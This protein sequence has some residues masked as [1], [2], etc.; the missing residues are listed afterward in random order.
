M[1]EEYPG[2]TVL[3]RP[4]VDALL[5]RAWTHRVSVISAGAGFG[6]TTA[7]TA[8]FEGPGRVE[9]L[10]IRASDHDV[11]VLSSRIARALGVDAVTAMPGSVAGVD[12]RGA[13]AE[14]RV[15]TLCEA[16][17][18]GNEVLLILDDVD[19]IAGDP[20]ATAFMRSL[21]LQAPL[22]LHVMLSGRD[23]QRAGMGADTRSGD[24]LEIGASDLAFTR[25]EVGALLAL[26]ASTPPAAEVVRRCW[27]L[28]NGWP[29]AVRLVAEAVTGANGER[30][31][32]ALSGSGP[33]R[34][35]AQRVVDG[36]LDEVR[37]A[38]DV[39]SV[40]GTA[41][42]D[43]LEA[44]GLPGDAAA[45]ADLAERGLLVIEQNPP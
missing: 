8:G 20:D 43:L 7:L 28:T 13:M 5:S 31:V 16:V 29:A 4:R 22:H 37:D 18:A 10:P 36:E 17:P 1:S 35:F 42:P 11:A 45:L 14:A 40:V 41:G 2:A 26:A 32:P 6:K 25:D 24:V 44:V 3:P 23:V 12:D 34:R 9:L 19:V 30:G 33:W 38:L 39:L 15:A 27:T 21:C